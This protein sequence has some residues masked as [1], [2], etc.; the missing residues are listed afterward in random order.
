MY[1]LITDSFVVDRY[2]HFY[3]DLKGHTIIGYRE[4]KDNLWVK[5]KDKVNFQ[6]NK[7]D[8]NSIWEDVLEE[9]DNELQFCTNSENANLFVRASDFELNR[10]KK[11]LAKESEVL[12]D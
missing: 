10:I 5:L 11:I 9:W 12:N 7:N 1:N 3:I 6:Y 2:P 4:D 8:P